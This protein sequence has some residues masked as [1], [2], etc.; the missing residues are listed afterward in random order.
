M[1][2]PRVSQPGVV[3]GKYRPLEIVQQGESRNSWHGQDIETE[4]PV[5]MTESYLPGGLREGTS[6]RTAAR[7]MRDSEAM[8]IACPGKVATVIAVVEETGVLWTVAER[9]EGT[10]LDELLRWDGPFS[11]GRAARIGLEILDVLAAAHRAQIIH[12][13]LSPSQ[14]LVSEEGAVTVSGFGL[15]GATSALPVTTPTFA[16][17]EQARGENAGPA[18]DLWALGAILYALVE[19]RPPFVDRGS[20]EATLRAVERLP[21]IDPEN[22]GPLDLV[23]Q[24]L[25]RKN[26]RERLTENV[27]RK[28]LV[29]VVREH[30]RAASAQAH[31]RP[32]VQHAYAAACRAGQRWKSRSAVV[33]VGVAVVLASGAVVAAAVGGGGDT[34]PS[35]SDAGPSPSPSAPPSTAPPVSASPSGNNSGRDPVPSD[36]P[37]TI[38]PPRSTPPSPTP[39]RTA[40]DNPL[41]GFYRYRAP[42]GFSVYLPKGFKRVQTITDGND[43]FRAVFGASGDPR[44][45]VVT[46][47]ERLKPDPVKVWEK[48]EQDLKQDFPDYRRL[49]D[50]GALR[51]HG[52][53]GAD[54]EWLAT[55]D[56]VTSR[57]FGRGW[58]TGAR[59][60]Y[61]LRWTTPADDFGKAANRRALS[62][63]LETFKEATR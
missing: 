2:E 58:L 11:P 31:S 32:R 35:A 16:S 9:V 54:M 29:R 28:A 17:P 40:P 10:P 50:I 13:D 19:G 27:A 51:Y 45:L 44:T 42:E 36:P 47:A 22:A 52:Y 24:G 20:P 33:W 49:G 18:S 60:G 4:Q 34:G 41:D 8:E 15:I 46:F 61:S 23:I 6:R 1:I 56:D 7:I 5:Y 59:E 12:G 63:F 3:G 57:T 14:V 53:Q 55:V 62:N 39:S 30:D 48:A 26:W 21:L 43:S 37:R 25:L 38:T